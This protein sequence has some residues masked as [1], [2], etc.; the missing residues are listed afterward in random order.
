MFLQDFKE[1]H[2]LKKDIDHFYKKEKCRLQDALTKK[3]P[4][5][6]HL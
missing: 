5:D 6:I 1:Y 3:Y 2:E 4:T